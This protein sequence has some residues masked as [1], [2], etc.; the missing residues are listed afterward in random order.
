MSKPKKQSYS[1]MIELKDR[2]RDCTA[3]GTVRTRTMPDGTVRRHT[4]RHFVWVDQYQG[5]DCPKCGAPLGP[6]YQKRRQRQISAPT[7]KARDAEKRRR[8]GLIDAGL[9]AFPETITNAVYLLD[10]WLDHQKARVAPG[11]WRRTNQL[12]RTYVVPVIGGVEVAKTR[13][14]H[15]AQCDIEA[16]RKGLASSTRRQMLAYLGKAF[17]DA[18]EWGL[19]T[20]NPV[21]A[22]RKPR[23][24][25]APMDP[26]TRDQFDRLRALADDTVWA[27]PLDIAVGTGVRRGENLALRWSDLDFD[28]GK[29]RITRSLQSIDGELQFTEPKTDRA[30]REVTVPTFVLDRLRRHKRAQAERRLRLGE[31]WHD[32]DLI[33]DRGDGG[34]LHPDSFSTAFKRLAKKAGLRPDISLHDLRHA[35]ATQLLAG[36]V[37]P[38]IASVVLGHAN[39]AF[40]MSQYQHVLPGMSDVAAAAIEEAFGS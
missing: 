36:G 40:T 16:E 10:R 17:A 23:V 5:D 7:A 2:R 26:P 37:H 32:L 34:P 11:T 18:V 6:P 31:A 27:V 28:T 8:L 38:A 33:S 35:Y 3:P 30:R 20:T 29:L 13:P 19:C 14:A 24:E 4:D 21:R 9:D 1:T 15:I 39:P 22:V 12:L 25:R